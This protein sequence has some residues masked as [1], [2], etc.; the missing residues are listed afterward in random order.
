MAVS[1][2][3]IRR[4]R[5]KIH[6]PWTFAYFLEFVQFAATLTNFFHEPTLTSR[7]RH[8]FHDERGCSQNSENFE[9]FGGTNDKACQEVEGQAVER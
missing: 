1:L 8:P 4:L 3:R 5:T 6:F 7:D 9:T 2:I